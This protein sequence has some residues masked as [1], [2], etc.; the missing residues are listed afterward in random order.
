MIVNIVLQLITDTTIFSFG[1]KY[2]F[3]GKYY[4]DDH[5]ISHEWFVNRASITVDTWERF[6]AEFTVD[7]KGH[8]FLQDRYALDYYN[9]KKRN[10][11]EEVAS[12]RWKFDDMI[13][14]LASFLNLLSQ[15]QNVIF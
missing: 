1:S 13:S 4:F 14:M 10:L 5:S 2:P 12:L 8:F 6:N 7:T 3:L 9:G 11:I 15:Y